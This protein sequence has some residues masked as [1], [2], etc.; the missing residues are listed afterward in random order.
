MPD[1]FVSE[2]AVPIQN[3]IQE[4]PKIPDHPHV[5]Y[6]FWEK[7]AG[8][9][10]QN[11]KEDEEIILFLRRHPVTNAPWILIALGLIIVFPLFIVV[12][13][14][15]DNPF[16]FLPDRFLTFFTLFYY[17]VVFSYILVNFM[18]WF[19]NI[20]LITDRSVVDIDYDGL[21]HHDVAI[22]NFNLIQDVNYTKTGF[23]R[24]LFNY[25]DLFVQTA[26]GKENLEALGVPNPALASKIIVEKIGK[27]GKWTV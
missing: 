15:F 6:S 13:K 1:L 17:L 12:F 9:S 8:V 24:S 19:Y 7:P 23:F 27:G 18:K 2:K 22:T 10:F 25:G 3:R 21:L 11:Q 5:V 20:I 4:K 26:G 14:R 16:S